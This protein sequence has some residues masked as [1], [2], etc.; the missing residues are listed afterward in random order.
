[1]SVPV[2]PGLC[3]VT[4]RDRGADEV[5]ALAA[6][7]GLAGI[8]WGGDVH[9]PPGDASAA[10][11]LARRCADAGL[12]CPSYGSYFFA[13]FND[14]DDLQPVIDTTRALGASTIRIWT[15]FGVTADA[16]EADRVRVA[17]AVADAVARV[18]AHGLRV[19]LEFH[20]GTLTHT[21]A[22]A[23][24]LVG[25]A[26]HENLF[27]YWQPE[28]GAT[29]AHSLAE[30]RIVQPD[31]AHLHVFSWDPD[32]EHRRPLAH[33]ET[34]WTR[35]LAEARAP[36]RWN[37]ERYAFLEFVAGDDP[38]QFRADAATMRRWLDAAAA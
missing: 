35:V 4:F 10:T 1:M 18:A 5:I 6:D 38:A 22:S 34:M 7:A 17:D 31:V 37:E 12:A 24:W 36:G 30:F 25:R 9:L 21:A 13:G 20:P 16:P 19:G 28:A 23:A 3:S 8:E 14:T 26:M 2:R 27:T 33:L 29:D 15:A 11:A 32:D